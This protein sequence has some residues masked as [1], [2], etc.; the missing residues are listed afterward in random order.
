MNNANRF[1]TFSNDHFFKPTEEDLEKNPDCVICRDA[2]DKDSSRVMPCGHVLHEEC[3]K[4][5][6]LQKD[7]CPLCNHSLFDFEK[8]AE[9]RKLVEPTPLQKALDDSGVKQAILNIQNINMHNIHHLF[10]QFDLNE[11]EE[12]PFYYDLSV[13]Q[14]V[15]SFSG[16][17]K[18]CYLFHGDSLPLNEAPWKC[19]HDDREYCMDETG[20][21]PCDEQEI[22]PCDEHNIQNN[23][24]SDMNEEV[25]EEDTHEEMDEDFQTEL[26]K[27]VEREEIAE[28]KKV[29]PQLEV[30]RSDSLTKEEMRAKRL[31][32]LQR[33][34]SHRE[35][36]ESDEENF[37]VCSELLYFQSN[38]IV[39]RRV[40]ST[41]CPRGIP[42][43]NPISL[44]SYFFH[45]F[46]NSTHGCCR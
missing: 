26:H 32:F 44:F 27:E 19:V 24:T 40:P 16:G 5:W 9:M 6:L 15:P 4:S 2:N 3:L 30:R 34:A 46:R 7:Q 8:E 37:S 45:Y 29:E 38:C 25:H 1:K 14:V 20:I 21:H 11:Q 35:G 12:V 31:E 42:R 10:M 39:F 13:G 43:W 23:T 36:K 41:V 33:A 18:N 22:H 17:S 28:E